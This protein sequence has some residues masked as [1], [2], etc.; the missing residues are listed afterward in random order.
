M[1]ALLARAWNTADDIVWKY[2][3]GHLETESDVGGTAMNIIW[4]PGLLGVGL[5]AFIVLPGFLMFVETAFAIPVKV[6]EMKER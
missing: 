4:K 2:S 3:D 1:R 5:I 6:R